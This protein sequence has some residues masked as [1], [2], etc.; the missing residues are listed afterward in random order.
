MSSAKRQERA[1]SEVPEMRR[2]RRIHFIGIGGSGMCGI[3]EVLLN[4]GYRITGS[5]L[6]RSQACERL[7]R[8]GAEVTIGQRAENVAGADVVV[9]SSAIAEDN[10]ELV[11]AHGARIPVVRRAEML[12]ELM[13]YRHGIAVAGTHGKTTTTS[14]VTSILEAAGLDPTFVIGGLL[15]SAGANARLGASRHLVAEA[16]ESD[17]SF[18]HLQPMAAVVTNI[19][20]DHMETY[21]GD[22]ERLR[23]AFVDFLHR[24]PFYGV[25]VLCADDPAV[26]SIL[27]RVSRPTITYGLSEDADV[28]AE[29]VETRERSSRFRVLR[30]DRAP[31]EI[32]MPLPGEHNVLNAL[33]AIAVATDE[34]VDDDAIVRGLARFQG[35]GRRF[36]VRDLII[37]DAS[38][39]LVDDYGHHPTEVAAVIRTARACWPGRRLVMV[40]Q[41]HRY[42]RTR[43]LYDDFVRVLSEV[44]LLL[45]L[46]VYAAGEPPLAGA[47]GRALARGVRQW[48]PGTDPLFVPGVEQVP[49]TLPGVLE[50]GD[51][52][53]TQ[54]AGDVGRLDALL[55]GGER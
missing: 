2:I 46:E 38:V 1:L 30:R 39:T 52:V 23:D 4:Q 9:V 26:R 32:S 40:Y 49:E 55:A 24:L 8:L 17:A 51:V 28:R 31:L 6:A 14:L 20:A 34:G 42:T 41:P 50:D 33:A 29:G 53:I 35:V 27:P 47:D 54:G 19:D 15:N 22:F 43:D 13:R 12:G 44:D 5:D 45:L 37:G 3:A 21:G 7:E 11:A 16:D 36:Q 25:A 48:N 18:L 10:P